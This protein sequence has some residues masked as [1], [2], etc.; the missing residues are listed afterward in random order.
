[1][2]LGLIELLAGFGIPTSIYF[3]VNECY[4]KQF[5][6]AG[7]STIRNKVRG[8]MI[9]IS[10]DGKF[11]TERD[12]HEFFARTGAYYSFYKDLTENYKKSF[13]LAGLIFLLCVIG[14]AYS[15][16]F[17]IILEV[18]R[19]GT[20]QP[21]PDLVSGLVFL[22]SYLGTA[23][24]GLYLVLF[25]IKMNSTTRLMKKYSDSGFDPQIV[26]AQYRGDS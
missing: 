24:S 10:K 9:K 11:N 8:T 25:M 3:V 4:L 15:G 22:I 17:E 19:N 7:F 21:K 23:F 6:G 13:L 20:V 16:F 14:L 5:E 12:I 18:I 26:I 1:M 2:A